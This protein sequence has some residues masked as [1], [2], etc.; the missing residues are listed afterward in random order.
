MKE[1]LRLFDRAY[2]KA[3]CI[4]A[5][6]DS[7]LSEAEESVLMFCI[8]AYEARKT[9]ALDK[10]RQ[11]MKENYSDMPDQQ[12]KA[13]FKEECRRDQMPFSGYKPKKKK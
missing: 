3:I 12:V 11:Y 6:Q 13:I 5:G 4:Q 1:K 8:K 7:N 2:T 10:F 9:Q